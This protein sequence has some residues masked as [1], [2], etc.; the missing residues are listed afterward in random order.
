MARDIFHQVL[1]LLFEA[2]GGNPRQMVSIV[3]VLK[4]E[5]LYGSIET[6]LTKLHSEGWIADAPKQDH[7]FVTVWGVEELRRAG[8]PAS[9]PAGAPAPT[10]AAPAPPPK[11]AEAKNAPAQVQGK[12]DEAMKQAEQKRDADAR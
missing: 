2:A 7:V 8:G 6:I 10:K 1:K 12:L 4:Q 9:Q 3:D 11:A 5:R